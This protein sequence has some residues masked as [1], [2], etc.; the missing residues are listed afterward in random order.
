MMDKLNPSPDFPW[1]SDANRL[2]DWSTQ[3]NNRLRQEFGA[4]ASRSNYLLPGSNPSRIV[5]SAALTVYVSTTGSNANDGLSAATPWLTTQHAIDV[6]VANYDLGGQT[7]TIQLADGTYT[8]SCV[9]GGPFTGGGTVVI[10]GNAASPGNV[11]VNAPNGCFTANNYGVLTVQHLKAQSSANNV[12]MSFGGKLF[13]NDIIFDTTTFVHI[14]AS[15]GGTVQANGNYSI[16]GGAQSHATAA[17]FGSIVIAHVNITITGTPA[18][19][20]AFINIAIL[21]FLQAQGSS[22]I[23]S[24]TGTRHII[25]QNSAV[26]TNGGGINFFPGNSPGSTPQGGIL[27]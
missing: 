8:A 20:T 27:Q 9:L 21:S 22:F 24:A 5:L 1:L 12:L 11:L 19:S 6:L 16:V 7:V 13:F 3:L 15:G 14:F 2:V 10:N 26:Q 23:G 18:F 4:N 25:Q 17:G